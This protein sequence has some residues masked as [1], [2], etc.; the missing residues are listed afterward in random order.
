VTHANLQPAVACYRCQPG[1]SNWRAMALDVLRIEEGLITE[2]VTFGPDTFPV[3]GLR[4]LMD[5]APEMNT[6]N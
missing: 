4:L 3:L 5:P 2:I 6:R 1:D